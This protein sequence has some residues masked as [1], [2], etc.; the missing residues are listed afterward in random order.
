MTITLGQI[1]TLVISGFIRIWLVRSIISHSEKKAIVHTSLF[2]LLGVLILASIGLLSQLNPLFSY[3]RFLIISTIIIVILW[4]QSKRF[5]S[6]AIQ[7]TIFL[8][9]L[10]IPNISS[11]PL[12]ARSEESIKRSSLQ[13][14]TSWPLWKIILLCM[15]S[16]LVFAW[17][18]TIVYL[19]SSLTTIYPDTV[20]TNT[21]EV[22]SKR[23]FI[24][25]ILHIGSISLSCILA[26]KLIER[27]R[28]SILWRAIWLFAWVSLHALFNITQSTNQGILSFFIILWCLAII[29][30]SLMRSDILYEKTETLN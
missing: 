20:N 30:Y 11:Y 1:I 6:W 18:E 14:K 9:S 15:I 29:S 5:I 4:F 26:Y 7:S 10:L 27:N 2:S 24:P 13:K 28:N 25:P 19:I 21:I 23:S 17:W 22:I 8:L 12:L 16:A 3:Q